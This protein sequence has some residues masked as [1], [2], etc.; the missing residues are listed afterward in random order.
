MPTA[1]TVLL[2]RL[3]SRLMW[4][5]FGHTT[6]GLQHT[7]WSNN[8]QH[9]I[10]VCHD[11]PDLSHCL[12]EW[13]PSYRSDIR[14]C[15]STADCIHKP[16]CRRWLCILSIS[17]LAGAQS[18]QLRVLIYFAWDACHLRAEISLFWVC[19][20]LI[21]SLQQVS[22]GAECCRQ[23]HLSHANVFYQI[24]CQL[25]QRSTQEAEARP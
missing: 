14:L 18:S 2:Y 9:I 3:G 5:S 16:F 20:R 4:L 10:S 23:W 8:M 1:Q 13:S 12:W 25:A 11:D 19:F 7:P 22:R 17:S 15:P 6:K 24:L 21:W